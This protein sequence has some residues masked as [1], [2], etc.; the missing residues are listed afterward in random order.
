MGSGEIVIDGA[1]QYA[2]GVC[3]P[4]PFSS[5]FSPPEI[6]TV[7][8]QAQTSLA[9]EH[10]Q[11]ATVVDGTVYRTT[12]TVDPQKTLPPP[13]ARALIAYS[14]V[15]EQFPADEPE[16]DEYAWY[17]IAAL[18]VASPVWVPVWILGGGCTGEE[19]PRGQQGGRGSRGPTGFNGQDCIISG[20]KLIC[21][22]N[23]GEYETIDL[24]EVPGI[25]GERGETG[26]TGPAGPRGPTGSQGPQG[27]QGPAGSGGGIQLTGCERRIGSSGDGS[28]SHSCSASEFM[29][30][31]GCLVNAG[32]GGKISMLLSAPGSNDPIRDW[33][34]VTDPSISVTAY[35]V[36]CP[37]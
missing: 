36:C 15:I 10:Q 21:M 7:P 11:L 3:E 24:R 16:E 20:Y 22:N 26:L 27:L 12:T 13:V 2:N 37:F 23:D 34:C 33:A 4:I 31:G 14:E 5:E 25:K 29:L 9:I 8:D 28:A 35:I 1:G 30:S 32:P 18:V 6:S 17:E 19:G